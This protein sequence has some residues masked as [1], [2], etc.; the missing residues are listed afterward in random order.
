MKHT[1]VKRSIFI[2]FDLENN[3]EDPKFKVGDHVEI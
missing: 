2:D 3:H 1:D